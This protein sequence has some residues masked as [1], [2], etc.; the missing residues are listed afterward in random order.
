MKRYKLDPMSEKWSMSI[1]KFNKSVGKTL[2]LQVPNSKIV[3]DK[4]VTEG[5]KWHD[6]DYRFLPMT[7]VEKVSNGDFIVYRIVT[8]SQLDFIKKHGGLFPDKHITSLYAKN[9]VPTRG[10]R[11]LLD[12]IKNSYYENEEAILLKITVPPK[13]KVVPWEGGANLGLPYFIPLSQIEVLE[14]FPSAPK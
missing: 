8:Q 5:N 14:K 1:E 4:V 9:I 13:T 10:N 2:K 7:T 11:E 12:E 6:V 3:D